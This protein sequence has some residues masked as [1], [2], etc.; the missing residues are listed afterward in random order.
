M[1][2]G[3]CSTDVIKGEMNELVSELQAEI[4]DLL[5]PGVVRNDSYRKAQERKRMS[6][7]ETWYAWAQE[8]F[9][10]AVGFVMG[11]ASFTD[12]YSMYFRM[13]GRSEYHVEKLAHRSHPVTW[14]RIQ[15]LADRARQMGYEEVS[16]DLE[17]EWDKIASALGIVKNYNGFYDPTFL[18]IIQRKL[19]D[20][21]TETT[22]REFHESEVL[23]KELKSTFTS[24][25]E[26]LN[27]AWQRFRTDPDNYREWE[28]NAIARFIETDI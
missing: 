10:D 17:E 27:S 3:T 1:N 15:L 18:P 14:I 6:I 9:C 28:E 20:M 7:V 8:F 16:A 25:V 19:N 23:G 11:G 13:L 2:L 21:L 24:P 4:S 26:L 12:A 22:P 5:A